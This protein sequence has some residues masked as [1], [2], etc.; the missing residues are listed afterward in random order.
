[1]RLIPCPQVADDAG[2]GRGIECRERFVQQQRTGIGHQRARE[3]TRCRSP[4]EISF[5]QRAFR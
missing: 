3:C 2:L 5:G 4:P 1:M